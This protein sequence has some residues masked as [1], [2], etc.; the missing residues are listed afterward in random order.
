MKVLERTAGRLT[1]EDRPVFLGIFMA[2]FILGFAWRGIADALAGDFSA[3]FGTLA[4]AVGMT[5]LTF[6][7]LIEVV[8][9]HFDRA[10]GLI[11]LRRIKASGTREESFPLSDLR[12]AEV[13]SRSASGSG[14]R[15]RSA[16][17]RTVLVLGADQR[18]L[19][20]S[21][22]FASGPAAERTAETINQWWRPVSD[23]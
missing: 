15:R 5:A 11:R 6:C 19:P 13:E 10:E 23:G 20:L 3:A 17:H 4:L 22:T 7:V 14:R 9:L 21:R 12:R 2:V 18:R 1:L 8:Q 16:T